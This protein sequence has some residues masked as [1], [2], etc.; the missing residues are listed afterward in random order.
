MRKNVVAAVSVFLRQDPDVGD[1]MKRESLTA[2]IA[3]F[4][5]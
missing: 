3:F 2:L 5:L 4:F 1:E